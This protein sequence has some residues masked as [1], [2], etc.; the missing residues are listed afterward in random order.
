LFWCEVYVN[1]YNAPVAGTC[2]T[3]LEEEFWG[4]G[5]DEGGIIPWKFVRSLLSI[6]PFIVY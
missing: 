3:H 1:R 6:F 5:Q 4:A 2:T